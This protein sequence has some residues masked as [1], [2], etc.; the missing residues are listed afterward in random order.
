MRVP[1][2]YAS[3]HSRTV[4]LLLCLFLGG[5]GAHRFYVGKSGS[6]VLMLILS[7]CGVGW[8]WSLID[9]I[10]ILTGSF[11]DHYGRY[12]TSWDGG[13][14]QSTPVVSVTTRPPPQQAPTHPV[15]PPPQ[16]QADE[17]FCNSCGAIAKKDETFCRNCGAALQH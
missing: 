3:H 7:L 4:A 10:M 1:Q 15:P 6:A 11:T 13:P 14:Q 5:F 16:K 8:I 12:V 9:L 17:M 2:S